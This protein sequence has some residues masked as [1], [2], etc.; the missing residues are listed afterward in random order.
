[1]L[2]PSINGHG[3]CFNISH[4]GNLGAIAVA[5]GIE[6]GIDIE[7]VSY[8]FPYWELMPFFF[9]STEQ[10][11]IYQ[12]SSPSK[13]FFNLW[14][15]KEAYIKA[16]GEGLNMPLD[17]IPSFSLQKSKHHGQTCKKNWFV[18]DIDP[19]T[20]YVG[21]LAAMGK[22]KRVTF[23]EYT[24]RSIVNTSPLADMTRIKSFGF[25]YDASLHYT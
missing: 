17:S 10:E 1:M 22:I 11:A 4:S 5:N 13:S 18:A 3:L 12:S 25:N 6:V 20:G 19:S 14:T 7:N 21:A 2:D 15:R 16:T 8:D 23:F 9:S 24:M